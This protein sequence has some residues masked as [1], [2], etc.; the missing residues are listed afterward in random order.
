M[1]ISNRLLP[2]TVAIRR[3]LGSGPMGD[4]YETTATQY[5]ARVTRENTLVRDSNGAEIVSSGRVILAP[6][7][8]ILPGSYITLPDESSERTVISFSPI[9]GS[10]T[11]HH[12]E[13]NYR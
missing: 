10:K 1:R 2:D 11:V 4:S 6:G 12:L 5:R 9:T 8:V 7:P 13:V 3:Y